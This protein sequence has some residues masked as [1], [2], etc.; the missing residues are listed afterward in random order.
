MAAPSKAS[1]L[2]ATQAVLLWQW[3][4]ISGWTKQRNRYEDAL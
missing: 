2:G 1:F 4:K 3:H